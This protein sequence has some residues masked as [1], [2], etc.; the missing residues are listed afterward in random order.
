[1]VPGSKRCLCL[2]RRADQGVDAKCLSAATS[3]PT[4]Q[5]SDNNK[6]LQF[7]SLCLNTSANGVSIRSS[8]PRRTLHNVFQT[9]SRPSSLPRSRPEIKFLSS[10]F[11]TLEKEGKK[12]D[13]ARSKPLVRLQ[14]FQEVSILVCWK[15][16]WLRS[17]YFEGLKNTTNQRNINRRTEDVSL[18]VL[19]IKTRPFSKWHHCSWK[20]PMLAPHTQ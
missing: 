12:N 15:V 19:L 3:S 4:N 8:Y 13:G 7:H 10:S 17:F 9:G 18:R 14:L 1:M 2:G 5:I 6:A 16:E 11:S 20:F